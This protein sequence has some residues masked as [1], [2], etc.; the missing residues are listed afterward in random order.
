MDTEAELVARLKGGDEEALNALYDDLSP[1]VYA[2]A[3]QLLGSREE[4]EEVLQDTFVSLYHEAWRYDPQRGSVRAFI[5]TMARNLARSRLR[6][7]KSRPRTHESWDVHDAHQSFAAPEADQ[8]T[9]IAVSEALAQ[10]E[11]DDRHLLEC[12][13]FQGCSHQQLIELTG[14][15]LGTVK[16]R[17]RRSLL[18]LRDY[19]EEA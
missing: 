2:L 5:Y 13:F 7:R 6:A 10:L 9:R 17:L 12:A 16:S 8:V 1:K 14:L 3:L 19:L 4:A 15:P 11:P 18:K